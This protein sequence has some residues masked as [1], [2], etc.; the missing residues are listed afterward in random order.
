MQKN[1]YICIA[2][3]PVTMDKLQLY[4]NISCRGYRNMLEINADEVIR[5]LIKDISIV[6][7]E[8]DYDEDEKNIFY[9]L[10][11]VRQGVFITLIRTIPSNKPDHLAA[12]IFV[13]YN[14]NI[15]GSEIMDVVDMIATAVNQSKIS[16]DALDAI[17]R[18]FD[19]EYDT[20]EQAGAIAPNYGS[21]YAHRYYG[22]STGYLLD[23][24]IGKS[25]YQ[26]SYLPY[27]GVILV[28][29]DEVG[30]VSD[31]DLTDEPL[32]QMVKLQPPSGDNDGYHPI[33]F[34]QTFDRPFLA[35]LMG[36]V[37]VVWEKPGAQDFRQSIM[38]NR[39]NM[40]IESFH[41]D[42]PTDPV[43]SVPETEAG[44]LYTN[45]TNESHTSPKK[46]PV[47]TRPSKQEH[48]TIAN[49]TKHD[50]SIDWKGIANPLN[51]S[52][53]KA[54][55]CA[56]GFILGLITA[57]AFTCS[58][59][60]TSST[61][62]VT[63]S[64]VVTT[65]S[66]KQP[67]S[68]ISEDEKITPIETTVK[69]EVPK[70][71]DKSISDAIAYLDNNDTWTLE[72]LESYPDLKGLYSDM[73]NF[74]KEQLYTKWKNKLSASER[75]TKLAEHARLG[76]KKA[77]RVPQGQKTYNIGNDHTIKIIT[78]LNTIDP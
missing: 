62:E 32:E 58:G 9:L 6:V 55:W 11:Y 21:R 47:S 38:V 40:R 73:N 41:A 15:T 45:R 27:S 4:I 67:I 65:D 76:K 56:I 25:R 75:F 46:T 18:T 69:E 34:G 48:H 24:L 8:V 17:R 74:R 42:K 78:Y 12:W 7:D 70:A 51:D 33:I 52:V 23:D 36:T 19:R 57:L 44:P 68:G 28:D 30:S 39:P 22:E 71:K 5:S 26:T 66:I 29:K 77:P 53:S 1:A 31:N 50:D 49:D 63:E 59:S 61:T 16:S 54:I 14:L 2:Q 13:P 10:K 43:K 72:E 64:T 37:E 20:N 60:D 35:P 3:K